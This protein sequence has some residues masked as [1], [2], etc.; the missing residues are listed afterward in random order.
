M[1]KNN[2]FCFST[3]YD[4]NESDLIYYGYRYYNANT[5]RWISP[6]PRGEIGGKDLYA[7]ACNDTIN[8]FDVLGLDVGYITV[9]NSYPVVIDTGFWNHLRGWYMDLRW[10]P[11]ASWNEPG[12][13]KQCY[14]AVWIQDIRRTVAGIG[15]GWHTDWDENDYEPYSLAWTPGPNHYAEMWDQPDTGG[16]MASLWVLSPVTFRARSSVKCIQGPD[17]G[18][19]YKTVNWGYDWSYDT[20]PTGFGPNI[21]IGPI[22]GD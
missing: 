19:I 5:G 12:G 8:R 22:A 9:V 20:T 1:A 17:A 11:P 10:T 4:D 16:T 2:P 21:S 3:K 14:T 18:S 13:C 7:D 15:I 6:D